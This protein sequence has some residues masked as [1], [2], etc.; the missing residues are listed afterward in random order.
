MQTQIGPGYPG[1]ASPYG[2]ASTASSS[3]AFPLPYSPHRSPA[4]GQYY[5]DG[6]QYAYHN[7]FYN[8]SYQYPPVNDPSLMYQ[9]YR[10]FF[11]ILFSNSCCFRHH[12]PMACS[13]NTGSHPACSIIRLRT[14]TMSNKCIWAITSNR[15]TSLNHHNPIHLAGTSWPIL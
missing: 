4:S 14:N 2:Y 12:M 13:S 9:V 3:P 1:P 8:P 10:L 11:L 7:R 15:M 6:F 5:S